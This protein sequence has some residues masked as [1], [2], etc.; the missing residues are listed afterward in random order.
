LAALAC[1]HWN[2]KTAFIA[3]QVADPAIVLSRFESMGRLSAGNEGLFLERLA[4]VAQAYQFEPGTRDRTGQ[5]LS[6]EYLA[7]CYG[8]DPVKTRGMIP[9][10][11]SVQ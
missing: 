5:F 7:C 11:P 2:Q 4:L 8:K 3:R 6:I 1:T 9:D 10:A